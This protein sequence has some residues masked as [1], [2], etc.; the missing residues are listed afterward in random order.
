MQPSFVSGVHGSAMG[1]V[2]RVKE[3]ER[4]E[5]REGEAERERRV[6]MNKVDGAAAKQ[7]V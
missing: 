7:H 1:S 3:S 5:R 2:S 4:G 6:E